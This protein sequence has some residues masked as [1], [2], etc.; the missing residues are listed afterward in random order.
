[1]LLPP[2]NVQNFDVQVGETGVREM[3]LIEAQHLGWKPLLNRMFDRAAVPPPAPPS[4]GQWAPPP[5]PLLDGQQ[6]DEVLA[7]FEGFL[8]NIWKVTCMMAG[9]DA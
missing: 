5:P 8:S 2:Q 6:V 9:A 1:M 7:G 3:F 4:A